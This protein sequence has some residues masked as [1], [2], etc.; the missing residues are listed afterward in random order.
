MRRAAQGH[1]SSVTA[2]VVNDR[3]NQIISL[4]AD[5]QVKVRR[6][7]AACLF[8]SSPLPPR[9]PRAACAAAS[10]APVCAPRTPSLPNRAA[11]VRG[12]PSPQL[13]DIRN[14]KCI[15]TMADR[16]VVPGVEEN[17]LLCAAYDHRRKALV[18]GADLTRT[19]LALSALVGKGCGR[20]WSLAAQHG[21][22]RRCSVAQAVASDHHRRRQLRPPRAGRPCPLQPAL[23]RGA[24]PAHLRSPL[25]LLLLLLPPLADSVRWRGGCSVSQAVSADA[26]GTVSVWFVPTGKLRFRFGNTHPGQQLTALN[27]DGPKRRLITGAC[28][29]T[30]PARPPALLARA[31]CHRAARPTLPA[32]AECFPGLAVPPQQMP[33]QMQ[34]T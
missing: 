24:Q 22:A 27:F 5:K 7:T 20:A 26:G 8:L 9:P 11:V 18:T 29:S 13:W 23:R 10:C 15:Q 6:P 21:C 1:T 12:V 25:L 30:A 31:R 28:A 34:P 17:T 32:Y 14:H 4:G 19:R 3:D 2:V 16:E 33:Q